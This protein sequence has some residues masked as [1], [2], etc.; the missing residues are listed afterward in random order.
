MTT[1]KDWNQIKEEFYSQFPDYSVGSHDQ[2]CECYKCKATGISKEDALTF[3][4]PYFQ[5]GLHELA[6]QE[7]ET[8]CQWEN[9]SGG[10]YC[11]K[12]SLESKPESSWEDEYARDLGMC[13][14]GCDCGHCGIRRDIVNKIEKEAYE[15]G[16]NE[17]L[18]EVI[19]EIPGAA[20]QEES[21]ELLDL[22]VNR[23]KALKK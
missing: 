9:C 21:R 1:N 7:L 15:R 23:L 20:S 5:E 17:G 10:Q 6:K 16:W 13:C 14:S 2:D 3:F 19:N 18:E 11:D 12:H 8:D 22:I 4:K